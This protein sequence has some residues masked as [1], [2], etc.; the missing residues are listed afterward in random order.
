MNRTRAR[1]HPAQILL[2]LAMLLPLHGL[3]YAT[4]SPSFQQTGDSRHFPETGQT[5]KGPFLKYWQ[6]H[7]GLSQQGY[8]ISA[9]MQERSDTDGKTYTVQYFERAVFELHPENKPPHDVLLSLLGVFLYQQKYPSGAPNQ[10]PNTSP[11]SVLFRKTGKRLGGIFLDYWK[12]N[13]ALPQQGFPISDEF[14]EK[15]DLDG[16]TY[17]VQYFERAVFEHHPEHAGTPYEVLLSHLGKFRYDARH[18]ATPTATPAPGRSPTATIQP[19]PQQSD[20]AAWIRQRAVPFQ[21]HDPGGDYSDLAPL[22]QI[23]GTARIVGLGEAT[24]GTHEFFTMK[25]RILEFLVKEMGFNLFAMEVGW[26]DALAVNEYVQGGPGDPERM[27]NEKM[28]MR[29]NEVR[30][31]ADLLRWMRAHNQN[32][33]S[34]PRV[35]FHGFDMQLPKAALD[36]VVSYLQQVD[37]A[38]A[39]SAV[40]RFAC[41]RPYEFN[42]PQYRALPPETRSRC[43]DSLR[44]VY[45]DLAVKRAQYEQASSPSD[46]ARALQSARVVVQSEEH[47]SQASASVRDQY[48]AENTAWVLE[49]AGP[50]AKIALWAH[51]FHIGTYTNSNNVKSQGAYLRDR[52]GNDMVTF[53][54]DFYSGS[55]RAVDPTNPGSIPAHTVSA[56]PDDTYEHIFHSAGIPRFFLDMREKSAGPIPEWL[57]GPRR[58]RVIGSVYDARQPGNYFDSVSLPRAF[59][60]L[61]YFDTTTAARHLTSP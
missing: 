9:E 25:H 61:V 39:E 31:I 28:Y 55:V 41:Y 59:D 26:A 15:S 53:G 19:T 54:F 10:Q 20:P 58:M 36:L 29:V 18:K 45:D 6:E 11:G 8:P 48:M 23:I 12:K 3:G 5:V 32:P 24:H 22:K 21:R 14:M 38:A 52:Y 13:G 30:E 51:N 4:A 57:S 7:G 60:V 27:L 44:Q 34:A 47:R 56:P 42:A 17:R 2:L 33:G 1:T 43:R 49:Q 35:S 46:F 50:G 16:K 37:P 40:A